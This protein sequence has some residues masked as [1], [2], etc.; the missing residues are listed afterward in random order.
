MSHGQGQGQTQTQKHAQAYRYFLDSLTTEATRKTYTFNLN[1]YCRHINVDD[2]TRLLDTSPSLAEAQIIEYIVDLKK[3]GRS[4]SR[5]NSCVCA[6]MHFYTM[7]DVTLNR[8]KIA[9][10]MGE[11]KKVVRSEA[12]TREQIARMLSVS[13]ERTKAIILL[14][15]STGIR[16]G[17]VPGLKGKHFKPLQDG[18]SMI[19]IYDGEYF[20]FCTP[21][22]TKAIHEYLQY[23]ERCG[24]KLGPESPIIREQFDREDSL[25]ARYPKAMKLHNLWS[26][27]NETITKAGVRERERMTEGMPI[28]QH[29]KQIPMAHG[30]RRFF[31]T[32]LMNADVHPSFKKLLMGHSV[33]LDEV[34]YDKGSDK[35]RAK[36]LE[37]YS[38]AI[39]ALTINEENRLRKKVEELTPKSDE[40]EAM[41]AELKERR[42]QGEKLSLAVD[43]LMATVDIVGR[44][45]ENQP[46]KR[47]RRKEI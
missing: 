6:I 40:I 18:V 20:A 7:N 19:A 37:E 26:L 41:K 24:E 36:L 46:D 27:V 34:Y 17:A 5:I 29:R 11:D 28:G 23:R 15:S 32:A 13:D 33:Q 10:F 30:F 21:E 25:K 4:F 9:R 16:I 44:V 42:E 1:Q 3:N 43:K 38:K 2:C 14:L 39:D 31:N 22:A 45:N 47:R 8:K 35:S 12:Y